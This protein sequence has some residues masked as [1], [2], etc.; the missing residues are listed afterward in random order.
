M[1]SNTLR[2]CNILEYKVIKFAGCPLTMV[3]LCKVRFYAKKAHSQTTVNRIFY[4]HACWAA[5]MIPKSKCGS[6]QCIAIGLRR[7]VV[8]R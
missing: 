8:F 1:R 4:T 7:Q 6:L 3:M 5:V 2:A